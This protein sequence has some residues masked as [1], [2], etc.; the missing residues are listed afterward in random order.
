MTLLGTP[1]KEK[2]RLKIFLCMYAHTHTHTHEQVFIWHFSVLQSKE[3]DG[4]HQRK[5]ATD[6]RYSDIV[7]VHVHT[8]T[9]I[10]T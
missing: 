4:S 6:L 7:S 10:H 1:K 8:Y 9:H 2:G 5:T 3:K